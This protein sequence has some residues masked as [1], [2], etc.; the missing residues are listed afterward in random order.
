MWCLCVCCC[1]VLMA[2][3]EMSGMIDVDQD[4]DGECA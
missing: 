2:E 3:D 1:S 4:L